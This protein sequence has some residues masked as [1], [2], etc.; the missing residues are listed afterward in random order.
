MVTKMV[1]VTIFRNK[2]MRKFLDEI[3]NENDTKNWWKP[4]L[5]KKFTLDKLPKEIEVIEFPSSENENHN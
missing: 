1:T 5:F 4:E 2:F 3:I